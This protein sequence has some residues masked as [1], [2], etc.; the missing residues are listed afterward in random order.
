MKKIIVFILSMLMLVLFN[1]CKFRGYFGEY[2]NLYTVATNSI[3]WNNGHSFG[4]DK[5]IDPKIEVI[6]QDRYGRMLFAYYEAYYFACYSDETTLS[7]STLLIMQHSSKEY[8]YYYEDYNYSIRRQNIYEPL[9]KFTEEDIAY[10]K[11]QNDWDK[12]LDLDKCVRKEIVN[13]KIQ[14]SVDSPIVEVIREELSVQLKDLFMVEHLTNDL[15]GNSIV[16]GSREITIDGERMS[17]YFVAFVQSEGDDVQKIVF[18]EPS[19]LYDYRDEFIEFKKQN[20]WIS[21]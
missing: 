19:D 10:L 9:K 2:T 3:L 12:P 1:G 8:V 21:K 18:F 11:L 15:V 16:Y 13:N 20:G 17:D 5:E 4:A 14:I 7:F 6:E